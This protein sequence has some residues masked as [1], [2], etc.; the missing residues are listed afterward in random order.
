METRF[1]L[2]LSHFGP[3]ALF[4]AQ[5]LGIFGLPIPDEFLL[6]VAGALAREGHLPI[7]WT[8]LAAVAGCYSGI[9]LSYV[10]GRTVGSKALHRLAHVSDAS[11]GRAQ[12]WFHR[13]G[14]W[15]LMFGYYIPGVRHCTA[16]AAGSAPLPYKEFALF[17]YTGGFLWCLSFLSFGYLTGPKWRVAWHALEGMG[18]YVFIPLLSALAVAVW[19]TWR[20]ARSASLD[21]QN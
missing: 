21:E 17:A 11:F 7:G 9:T 2:W 3:S 6:T 8:I 19:Y 5:M 20:R 13:Y 12:R 10:V 15:L 18:P 4:F 1:L 14:R 16:I